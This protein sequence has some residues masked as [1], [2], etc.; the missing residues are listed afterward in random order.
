MLRIVRA[1]VTERNLKIA[2]AREEIFGV[3]AEMEQHNITDRYVHDTLIRTC[4][5]MEHR[6]EYQLRYLEVAEALQL[7]N[8]KD[9]A[10]VKSVYEGALRSNKFDKAAKMASKMLNNFGDSSF[11]L[12]QIE[13]LYLDY[14]HKGTQMS[15]Q[16]AVAF[17]E[18][19]INALKTPPPMSF[20]NL[21]LKLL[22]ARKEYDKAADYI[23]KYSATFQ[24]WVERGIWELKILHSR[25]DTDGLMIRI[26]EMLTQNY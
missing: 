23:V 16:F 12:I 1:I 7:K 14:T 11:S 9:S 25:G 5:Q 18:K 3:L 10:L 17:A 20:S 15:L 8:P 2:E 19:Y 13:L 22:I 24:L 6:A 21:Y 26:E 4:A